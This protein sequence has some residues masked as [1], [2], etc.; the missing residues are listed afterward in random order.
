MS[1]ILIPLL[2]A[3]RERGRHSLRRWLKVFAEGGRRENART[4][5]CG[6]ISRYCANLWSRDTYN[7]PDRR[8][9]PISRCATRVLMRGYGCCLPPSPVSF[10]PAYPPCYRSV[11]ITRLDS[12]FC[13]CCEPS[14][15]L[16]LTT[17]SC[18]RPFFPRPLPPLVSR[19]PSSRHYAVWNVDT[20]GVARA[21][22]MSNESAITLSEERSVTR[23][24]DFAKSSAIAILLIVDRKYRG[25]CF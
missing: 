17:S 24:V 3:R 21:L 8:Y 25:F 10:P 7:F 2:F 19:T 9:T 12:L 16:P 23:V 4:L 15:P 22:T 11:V 18:S 13:C 6:V 5:S 20:E 1:P 14:P